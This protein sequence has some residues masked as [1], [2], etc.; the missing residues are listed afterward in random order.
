MRNRSE[1]VDEFGYDPVYEE[2]VLPFFDFLYEKYFRVEVTG[3]REHP[4]ARGAACSSPT[5]PGT[6]P[7]RRDDARGS[8]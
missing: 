8:R 4:G 6:L 1:E 2:Q 3:R 5:T 7:L